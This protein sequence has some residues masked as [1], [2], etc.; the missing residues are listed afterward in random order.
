MGA[1]RSHR[2]YLTLRLGGVDLLSSCPYVALQ[3]MLPATCVPRG[4]LGVLC[5]EL[6]GFSV[7]S[8]PCTARH[9]RALPAQE[10]VTFFVCG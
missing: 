1:G 3:L 5:S 4:V 10:G 6:A 9:V 8:R 7:L 2:H